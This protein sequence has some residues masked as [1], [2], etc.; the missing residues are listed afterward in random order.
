MNTAWIALAALLPF[1]AAAQPAPAVGVPPA[2]LRAASVPL[3]GAVS[4]G[5]RL[6]DLASILAWPL[7]LQPGEAVLLGGVALG[8][9][10]LLGA[11]THLYRRI[12][13]VNWTMNHKSLFDYTLLPGDGLV[14]LLV[15]GGFAFGDE[16]AR[17]TSLTGLE[18]LLSAGATSIVLKHLFRVPRPEAGPEDKRYFRQ[19]RADAFP[20]GHTMAAFATASV[21]SG[22]YPSAAPF[23]Y[24][25][26]SLVGLSVMKRGWHWPSDVLAGAA[27]GLLIGHIAVRV[28][29]RR[30]SLGPAP[31]G[32]G[33]QA[34]I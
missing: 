31:G 3:Q 12:D 17:R 5:G 28:N 4:A 19:F 18:A 10:G 14:N 2:A 25:I 8:T 33:I 6:L 9:A 13:R 7:Q 34:D 24:G 27:L 11:D 20:S 32:I 23:A 22:E 30:I 26:A 1:G 21:I 29:G 15:L 16:R